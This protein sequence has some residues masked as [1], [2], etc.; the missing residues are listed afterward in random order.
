[1]PTFDKFQNGI[2]KSRADHGGFDNLI[3]CD[4]HN[5][6][7]YVTPQLALILENGLGEPCVSC[8]TNAGTIYFFS[9]T[10]GNI[11]KRSLG[12][13]YS[14]VGTNANG[15]H[16]GCRV[17]NGI[18]FYWTASKLG[19]FTPET[20]AS[21]NDS[22]GTAANGDF[23]GSVIL[24]LL[25]WITDGRYITK[26]DLAGNFTA[27]AL[28]IPNEFEATILSPQ[29]NNLLVGSQMGAN[30]QK[31][32]FFLWDTYSDSWTIEDD[33]PIAGANTFIECDELT[34]AQCG[35]SGELWYWNGTSMV[36]FEWTV[37]GVSTITTLGHQLSTVLNKRPLF[38]VGNKIFSIYKQFTSSTYAIVQ[39]YTAT[40]T[41]IQSLEVSGS[42][43]IVSHNAGVD[44][45]GTSYA[46]ATIDTP[47]MTGEMMNNVLINYDS[48]PQG[49]G[50]WTLSNRDVWVQQ[51]PI[52]DTIRSI[53]YFDGGLLNSASTQARVT[54]TANGANVPRIKVI[55]VV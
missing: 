17:F 26:V 37:R 47:E 35:P 54:L 30:V 19:R 36:S 33:V 21:R 50:I 2:G 7:G 23:K 41:T 52:I 18:V 40:G 4:V 42:Q 10:T 25:L 5:E 45:I 11:W 49:I 16:R 8:I 27:N 29:K 44:K 46:V 24:N 48:Y 12:G 9:T 14:F 51:T 34:I 1:M 43:L 32:R 31:C 3:N 53:V 20:Q 15:A 38:A 13:T 6:L 22:I 39:E 55:T 28:D